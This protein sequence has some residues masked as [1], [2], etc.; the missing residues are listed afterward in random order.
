MIADR[1]SLEEM[2]MERGLHRKY[3]SGRHARRVLLFPESLALTRSVPR[4][5]SRREVPARG[6]PSMIAPLP[7][8]RRWAAPG[9]PP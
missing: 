6:S 4:S 3:W 9:P 7:F 8:R 2:P 1:A 5:P